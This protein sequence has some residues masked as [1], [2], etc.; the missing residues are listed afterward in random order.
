MGGRFSC[1]FQ[2]HL[3]Q[4]LIPLPSES[5]FVLVRSKT[6]ELYTVHVIY[7]LED[8][9]LSKEMPRIPS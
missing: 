4:H 3:V 6:H 7:G 5:S 2:E 8:T 9:T 1:M